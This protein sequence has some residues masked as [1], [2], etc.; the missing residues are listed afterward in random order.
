M[1]RHRVIWGTFEGVVAAVLL[2]AGG[3]AALSTLQTA[4]IIAALPFSLIM[5]L[6]CIAIIRCLSLEHKAENTVVPDETRWNAG[7]RRVRQP[8]PWWRD[9]TTQAT[10]HSAAQNRLISKRMKTF[11][12]ELDAQ[13]PVTPSDFAR[14]FRDFSVSSSQE[15]RL[16]GFGIPC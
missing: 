1:F 14:H 13:Y 12:V 3:S 8:R 10:S 15:D 11:K 2:V 4:A 6:M 9:W 5:V 16:L 7:R